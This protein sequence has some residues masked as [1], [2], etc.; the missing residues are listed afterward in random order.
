[1]YQYTGL[2][3]E[4]RGALVSNRFDGLGAK[5]KPQIGV[6]RIVG[7]FNGVKILAKL[8]TCTDISTQLIFAVKSV[9]L[10]VFIP[11]SKHIEITYISNIILTNQYYWTCD[12]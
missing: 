8:V 7:Y 2:K 12:F 10:F 11:S 4:N 9:T 5:L 6:Y 3:N 1:M